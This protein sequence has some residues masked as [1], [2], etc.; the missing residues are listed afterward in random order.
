MQ[1]DLG[2][3][4][5]KQRLFLTEHHRHVAFGGAR[6]GGKSWAIRAKAIALATK[7][8]GIQIMII[9]RT[10]PE[11][12]ANHIRPLK[13]LL[14]IGVKGCPIKY[15]DSN[16]IMTFPNGSTILFGYCNTD[17]DTDRYQGT[18][19]DVL[20]LDE[21][22]QLSEQQ[23]KDL[24]A[25]VRGTSRF[26]RRTYYTCNPGGKSHGYIKRLFVTR[27]YQSNEHPEDYSFIQS[28]VYDNDVLMANDPDY[29]RALEALPEAKR[30]AWLEGDWDS[31]IGQV[32]NEWRNDPAHYKDRLWT[33]VIDDFDIPPGWKIYR[34]YDHG[35]SK[36][37]S[38]GWFAVDHDNRIYRIREWYGC[39]GEPNVGLQLTVQEIARHIKEIEN[40]DPNLKGRKILGIADPAIWGSQSG[41]SIED[42][43]EACGV[44]C[45]KGDHTRLAGLMQFHYRLS[46]DKYGLPMFYTF[47]SCQHFIRCIPLLIYD[48]HNVEDIDTTMEDH[49]YDETR[50]I[51]MAHPLNPRK[52][53]PKYDETTPLPPEDPLDL[54]ATIVKPV[55]SYR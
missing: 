50:Y 18:E 5:K 8:P 16:K 55:K 28:L 2:R 39:T 3:P 17:A 52:N 34:G 38:V 19:V 41:E 53:M 49:N 26:P 6:G 7:W 36:P 48:E 32:F 30:K 25:C 22:T 33:H 21:A 31:F 15:N 42:M 47:K 29:V 54:M 4:N 23:I 44:Y 9:R 45:D 37:F 27:E 24:N 20:F 51:F 11:L 35:Y 40:T 14:H 13:K 43:F 10:Y 1:I 12:Q 46:F